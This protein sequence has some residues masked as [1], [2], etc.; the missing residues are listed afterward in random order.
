V[1]T[2]DAIH[3]VSALELQPAAIEFVTYDKQLAAIARASGLTVLS[4]S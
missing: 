4:P 3:L 1:R 2:L